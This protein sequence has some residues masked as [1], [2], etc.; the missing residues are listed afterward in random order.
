MVRRTALSYVLVLALLLTISSCRRGGPSWDTDISS[1]IFK[2]SFGID[3]LITD[4]LLVKNPDSTLTLTY[5]SNLYNF[6]L[7]SLIKIPD[8]TIKNTYVLPLPSY[9]FNCGQAI[10]PAYPG[11]TT[12]TS[13]PLNGVGLKT[14][15]LHSGMMGVDII[16]KVRK[17]IKIQYQIPSATLN[18]VPFNTETWVDGRTGNVPGHTHVDYD[19]SGYTIDMTGPNH[20]SINTVLTTI[21]AW[22]DPTCSDTVYVTNN[23]PLVISTNFKQ[24]VPEY[25]KGYFGQTVQNVGPS[26]NNFPLFSKISSGSLLLQSVQLEFHVE[27]GI[28]A[29]ARVII[30]DIYSRNS[31][32][33]STIHLT[34]PIINNPI[35]LNRATETFSIPPEVPSVYSV[36]LNNTNS[37]IRNLVQ[38]LPDKIGYKMGIY[39]NPMGNVS[40]FND[41][42]YYGYGIKAGLDLTIPLSLVANNLTLADTVPVNFDQSASN[43]E[44]LHHCLLTLYASNGFPFTANIQLYTLDKNNTVT[45]SLIGTSNLIDQAPLDANLKAIDQRQTILEIPVGASK[46]NDLVHAKKI[47]IIARFNTGAKPNYIKIYNDYRID[48]RLSGDFNYTIKLH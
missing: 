23:D 48:F 38:N 5:K 7:D 22:I 17:K 29:D 20:N 13:Y 34:A 44:R 26:E 27:N 21:N 40:G 3:N 42:I 36:T 25:A 32:T 9:L 6:S 41:F 39:P 4:S 37:N 30:P 10:T 14:S 2:T 8:T 31:R 28:G 11:N 43:I 15:I 18:G 46:I 45:D 47:L 19:L 12:Q 16:N 24:M 1:P 35:N 33:G